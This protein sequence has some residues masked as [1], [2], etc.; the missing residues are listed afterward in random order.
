[1]EPNFPLRLES[2]STTLDPATK[3]DIDDFHKVSLSRHRRRVGRQGIRG[4]C[5][6]G[7]G[8]SGASLCPWARSFAPPAG[9]NDLPD[10]PRAKSK[11]LRDRDNV[12]VIIIDKVFYQ[13][14][15]SSFIPLLGAGSISGS[16]VKQPSSR[17]RRAQ[18]DTAST[19]SAESRR[20]P[21]GANRP[22]ARMVIFIVDKE[23]RHQL[24]RLGRLL[25]A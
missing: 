2:A 16:D 11:L 8:P 4:P 5:R 7:A 9:A 13:R 17:S 24:Q 19:S 3:K 20:Q 6:P 25:S 14:R 15:R 22:P 12:T 18:N 21:R 1:M 10:H 23:P